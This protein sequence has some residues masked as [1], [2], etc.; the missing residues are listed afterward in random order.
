MKKR[1]VCLLFM[2]IIILF[3]VS[4]YSKTK[5]FYE[6][7]FEVINNNENKNFDIYLLLP[8]E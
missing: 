1:I 4:S 8:E 3:N 7:Q 5:D 2:F 6:L